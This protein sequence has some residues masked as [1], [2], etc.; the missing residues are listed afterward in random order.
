M[1]LVSA[2]III[3]HIIKAPSGYEDENGFH[4]L[5]DKIDDR[6]NEPERKKLIK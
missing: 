6:I 5:K 4:S 3:Y 1:T 2:L